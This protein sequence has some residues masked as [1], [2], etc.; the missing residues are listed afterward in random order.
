MPKETFVEQD[1]CIS[2]GICINNLPDV[3][4]FETQPKINQAVDRKVRITVKK[5]IQELLNN[6]YLL[7]VPSA[8]KGHQHS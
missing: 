7:N 5:A 3:F 2:C 4:H 6:M 1:I 8:R